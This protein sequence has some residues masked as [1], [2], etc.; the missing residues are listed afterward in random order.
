HLVYRLSHRTEGTVSSAYVEASCDATHMCAAQQGL[1]QAMATLDKYFP[2]LTIS[3]NVTKT[4]ASAG[5][6]CISEWLYRRQSPEC[7]SPTVLKSA[8]TS[9]QLGVVSVLFLWFPPLTVEQC[10]T[11]LRI[12]SCRGV[13]AVT[14]FVWNFFL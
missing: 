6:I 13:D 11:V 2:S 12:A 8:A 3:G 1:L 14:T 4:A 9:G 5:Y 7:W 10:I